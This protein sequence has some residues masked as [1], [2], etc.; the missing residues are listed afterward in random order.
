[1]R[2]INGPLFLRFVYDLELPQD[3]SIQLKPFDMEVDSF[4]VSGLL[5]GI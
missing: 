3:G 2:V 5:C 4:E 1:M